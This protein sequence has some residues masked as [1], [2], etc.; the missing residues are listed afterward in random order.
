M[1]RLAAA[2]FLS[3]VVCAVW[4]VSGCKQ[5][6]ALTP[7][8]AVERSANACDQCQARSCATELDQCFGPQLRQGIPVGP[9]APCPFDGSP[10]DALTTYFANDPRL[11]RRHRRAATLRPSDS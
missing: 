4:V 5:D 11:D 1:R 8:C 3:I 7:V 6:R 10:G 2:L 9:D